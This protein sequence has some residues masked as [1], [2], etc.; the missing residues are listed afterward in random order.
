[1][2]RPDADGSYPSAPR[3]EPLQVA[4]LMSKKHYL[5]KFDSQL[6]LSVAFGI[7]L[8][9]ILLFGSI[10]LSGTIKDLHIVEQEHRG[11][12]L[13]TT[14]RPLL[15]YLPQYRGFC[16]TY[17]QGESSF[18][19][20][21]I[22]AA[23]DVERGFSQ[24]AQFDE[25]GLRQ[26]VNLINE[27]WQRLNERI[28]ELPPEDIFSNNSHL[29][30][31]LIE[32]VREA[33]ENSNLMYDS[34]METNSLVEVA[35]FRLPILS[36]VIGQLRGRSSAVAT[37]AGLDKQTVTELEILVYQMR[38]S[39]M[40]LLRAIEK[41]AEKNLQSFKALE[42]LAKKLEKMI[43]EF[44]GLVT[45]VQLIGNDSDVSA[46]QI[47][48]AG[49]H[50]VDAIFPLYDKVVSQLDKT[51]LERIS[52]VKR[53]LFLSALALVLILFITFILFMRLSRSM[54]RVEM[55]ESR[56]SSIFKA[57]ADGLVVID[58]GGLIKSFNLAAEKMFGYSASE[59]IN[60]DINILLPDSY[61]SQHNDQ[62]RDYQKTGES[63]A[64]GIGREIQGRHKDGHTF[65]IELTVSSSKAKEESLFTAVVRDITKRK[66]AE[67][68]LR[69][70]QNRLS[71]ATR[72]AGVGVWDWDVQSGELVW[73]DSMFELYAVRRED[74]SGAYEVWRSALHK[75]DLL[76]AEA[77]LQTSVDEKKPFN[78]EFRI[79]HP[80]GEIRYISALSDVVCDALGNVQRV[81][82]INSD[83]TNNKQAE[84]EL[85]TQRRQI[86]TINKAQSHFISGGDPIKFFEGILP[87][88]L[89]L[90]ASEFG[91]IGESMADADGSPYIKAYAITD[92]TWD[93]ATHEFYAMNAPEGLE[94]RSLDNLLGKVIR[95]GE[96]VISNDPANDPDSAG[97]PDGHPPLNAFL[98]VPVYL[99]SQMLGMIGLANRPG[100]YD[101]SVVDGLLPVL[102]ICAQ[103]FNAIG[104]ERQQRSTALEL[105]RSNSFMS[106]LIENLPAGLLVEDEVGKVYALNQ[107][108]CDMFDK[109]EMPLMIEGDDCSNEFEQ[110]QALLSQPE[111]LRALRQECLSSLSVIVGRELVLSDGRVYE[112]DYVP[113]FL[114]DEKGQTHRSN[115][116][117]YRDISE[118]KQILGQLEQQGTQLE[119]M[120]RFVERTLDALTSSVCVLDES[121]IILYVNEAWKSFGRGNGL[122]SDNGCVGSNYL[123][124]CDG[125]EEDADARGIG[126]SLRQLMRG[127]RDHFVAEYTCHSP[128]QQRWMLL[129]ATRF[130][131]DQG[132]RLV[133][134][135]DDVT[136][137]QQAVAAAEAAATAK[138]QFL[139]TMSHELRTPMN[140][141][142]GMLQLMGK[143]ELDE[144]QRRFTE[145]ATHSGE[146]LLTVI[147]DV[148]DFS[149]LEAEKLELE[150]I[151]FDLEG[152]LEQTVS[153]L[154]RG[155]QEKGV[156]LFSSVDSDLPQTLRGDPTRLR[157]VLTNL[158][159]NAIKFTEHG[160][161]VVYAT[162][163]ESGLV[164]L[165]V[166]DT[167]I[168]MT[169]EQQQRLF[170]A[171]SQVDSSHTRKYGGTGLG[172]A[173]SQ[174]LIIAMGGKIRVASSPELGSD[175]NFDL[176]LEIVADTK[177]DQYESEIL[178]R[179]RILVVDDNETVLILIKRMLTRW[180][181]SHLGLAMNGSEALAQLRVA[182]VAGE[183]YDI[184]I[185]DL[186]MPNMDGMEL[187]HTIRADDSLHD[188]KLMML[189]GI[190]QI[191]AASDVDA[192]MVKPVRKSGLFNTLLQLLGEKEVLDSATE[193]QPSPENFSFSGRNLLL[194]E[195]NYINQEVA[196]EILSEAGFAIDIRENGVEAIQAVQSND[197]DVV[198]MDIQMPVMDGLAAAERIR[199]LGGRYTQLPI[200]AMTAHALDGD[201]EKSLA[202][203]MDGHLTKP[204]DPA[205]L[206]REL[207]KWVEPGQGL[208]LVKAETAALTTEALPELPGIDVAD[209]LQR[210]NGNWLTY[211]RILLSFRD[212]HAGAAAR[213][214]QLIQ[215]SD[216]DEATRL[217]HTLK[218]SGGNLGAKQLYKTAIKMDQACR[219][220]AVDV[221][222]T[223][224]KLLCNNL[225]EIIDGL[226]VLE[227][228]DQG[229]A[230]MTTSSEI[231]PDNINSLVNE[232][233]EFLDSDLGAAQNLLATLQ[234]LIVSSENM[235]QIKA[236]E[237]ALNSFDI[238]EAKAIVKRIQN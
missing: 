48:D 115:L 145:N 205:V 143:T 13:I 182:A 87:D 156:E 203:G 178:A 113:I 155:A 80:N 152:L 126:E 77:E 25:L 124:V 100:G 96:H 38:R 169:V 101:I 88:I 28:F 18:R 231:N 20:P 161:I 148:L 230:T 167:G 120:Q 166:R 58:G 99:G 95:T 136:A 179:Q 197:Y 69:D 163:L 153:L 176:A 63:R 104:K 110:N 103:V 185:L 32:L 172:L 49:S 26:Q 16:S 195:D 52:H 75:D 190:E 201:A 222:S 44:Q 199:A 234:S 208:P 22:K 4:P 138:S 129:H 17:R 165:G 27:Q 135:H 150:S 108:Y 41:L 177:P 72:A 204:I 12:E 173:I 223:L 220:H 137:L 10:L 33:A 23:Q 2:V 191:D 62:L 53:D 81:V 42:L 73:D 46:K 97:L 238:E 236:L 78:I 59:I 194:V 206:F 1:M 130:E 35:V 40:Q 180:Q 117:S 188:M 213:L 105:K 82:G 149:K 5:F 119:Q 112:Q 45:E 47:F 196:R 131:T 125:A 212:K 237:N 70:S 90:T 7:F 184:A 218:G 122:R 8:S 11:L 79:V 142:L 39:N 158:I 109:D 192:W 24:I 31:K 9:L 57:V 93:D 225:T 210:L 76:R 209:G 107:T 86:E 102:N 219:N 227:V 207:A 159:N 128:D 121:G 114:E 92:I 106:G 202:A 168:G 51:L 140:G 221:N 74:F 171:F 214:E 54:R 139:A 147:N 85:E 146:M 134:A 127:V 175:F 193:V 65:P 3:D 216:W 132:L 217:V 181:V 233:A 66:Q 151:P 232:L 162:R 229:G 60:Q 84:A 174:K 30:T 123:E 50:A 157:Q 141:V 43:N 235:V 154:V 67:D 36:D 68:A 71:L 61:R 133:V 83:I 170:K 29:I 116:W 14:I 55:S 200:I 34:N 198:L 183:P 6:K 89:T 211:K 118:H 19:D 186:M 215:Q 187:A 226:A 160:D 21:C 164:R 56:L 98:S 37:V 144:K 228:E 15:Q 111:E 224:L 91:F 189:T 64:I 94:F